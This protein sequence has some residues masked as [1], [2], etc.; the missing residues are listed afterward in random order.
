MV[1]RI[2]LMVLA[3]GWVFFSAGF[4]G[5]QTPAAQPDLAKLAD[6]AQGWLADLVKINTVNPP[7]N[8]SEMR[9]LFFAHE[10]PQRVL[11]LGL[12]NEKIVFRSQSGSG[13]R[14]FVIEA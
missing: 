8:E 5:A 14:R 10:M 6:E 13:H 7:G 11:Q 9:N 4:A 12:L 3:F 1:R 2:W